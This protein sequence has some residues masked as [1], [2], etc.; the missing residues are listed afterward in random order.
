M[1]EETYRDILK[2]PDELQHVE[3]ASKGKQIDKR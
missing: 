1:C 2:F 3:S